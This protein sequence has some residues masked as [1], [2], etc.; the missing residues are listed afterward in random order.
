MIYNN[1]TIFAR[2]WKVTKS[3]KYIDLQISTWEKDNDGNTTYSSWYPRVVGH[4]FNTLKD[5]K[6]GD[7]IKI[8]KCKMTNTLKLKED[9]S[10]KPYFNFVIFEAEIENAQKNDTPSQ[11]NTTTTTSDVKDDDTPW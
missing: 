11:S 6:D 2:V 5:V 1:N 10:K 3:D 9:G 8:T 4:A 7:N